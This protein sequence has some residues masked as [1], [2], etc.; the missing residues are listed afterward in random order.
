MPAPGGRVED[1]IVRTDLHELYERDLQG[2]ALAYTP[3]CDS[4]KETEGFRYAADTLLPG[5]LFSPP[6]IVSFFLGFLF[7]W[8][9]LRSVASLGRLLQLPLQQVLE[10]GLLVQPPPWGTLSHQRVVRRRHQAVCRFTLGV[11]GKYSGQLFFS[12]W[13]G[14]WRRLRPP[15]C[16]I[17]LLRL[18]DRHVDL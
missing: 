13:I 6:C 12:F 9:P 4:R 11:S 18:T 17:E 7:F 5:A 3:F 15:I 14:D 8:S 1:Q 2:K 10:A 16:T